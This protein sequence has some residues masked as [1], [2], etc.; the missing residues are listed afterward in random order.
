MVIFDEYQGQSR[1][2]VFLEKAFLHNE[3]QHTA[4][5]IQSFNYASFVTK[6]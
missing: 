6:L 4:A 5:N 1:S 2:F 3:S